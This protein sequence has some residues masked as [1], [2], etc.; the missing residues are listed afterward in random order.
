MKFS[1]AVER[2]DRLEYTQNES[3]IMGIQSCI[4]AWMNACNKQVAYLIRSSEK[5][6]DL[7]ADPSDASVALLVSNFYSPWAP[8]SSTWKER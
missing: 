6:Q 7:C 8:L 5:A 2:L 3:L 4:Y 1:L